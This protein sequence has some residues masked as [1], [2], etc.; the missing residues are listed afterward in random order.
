MTFEEWWDGYTL[1]NRLELTTADLKNCYEAGWNSC[2][3]TRSEWNTI[4]T[5]GEYVEENS[6]G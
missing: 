2:A 1:M 6:D 5:Y 4:M 3:Y